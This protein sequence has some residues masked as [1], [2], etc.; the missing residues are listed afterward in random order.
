MEAC[1]DSETSWDSAQPLPAVSGSSGTLA[2]SDVAR[3]AY[4]EIHLGR[5]RVWVADGSV[6][7][8]VG[9]ASFVRFL[10]LYALVEAASED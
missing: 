3:G 8:F 9:N 4:A 5:E 7:W 1:Y 2:L 6:P 10:E